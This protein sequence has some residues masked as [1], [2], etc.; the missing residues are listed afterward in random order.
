MSMVLLETNNEQVLIGWQ[1][2]DTDSVRTTAYFNSLGDTIVI[3]KIM[4]TDFPQA[5][6]MK[7]TYDQFEGFMV[8]NDKI[9]NRITIKKDVSGG[10]EDLQVDTVSGFS[11]EL[12]KGCDSSGQSVNTL[13]K[14][15]SL[16]DVSD[17]AILMSLILT[18]CFLAVSAHFRNYAII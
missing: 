1:R 15:P 2:N 7:Q 10:L 4:E 17:T 12:F 5:V 9:A 14:W 8:S 11:A 13:S 6:A 3:D 16:G 18:N